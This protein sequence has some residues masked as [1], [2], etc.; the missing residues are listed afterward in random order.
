MSRLGTLLLV[1]LLCIFKAASGQ[2]VPVDTVLKHIREEKNIAR[3]SRLYNYLGVT[4]MN[5]NVPAATGFAR[6]AIEIAQK[7]KFYRELSDAYLTLGYCYE[8]AGRIDDAFLVVDSSKRAADKV[9]YYKGQFF[10]ESSYG[11]LFR[12]K[13][14]YDSSLLHY[15]NAMAIADK[16]GDDTL[17]A[18]GYNGLGNYYATVKDIKKAEEFHLQALEIRK[19]LGNPYDLYSNYENLGILYREQENYDKALFYYFKAREYAEQTKDSSSLA[20]SDND[21]GAAYS[22]KNDVVKGEFFLKRSIAIRERMGEMNELAYTYNYLGENYERKGDL[23]NAEL[24]IKKAL[25]FAKSIKNNKQIY[26]A[27]ES[28]SD[29]YSR[30]KKYDSA[31][32]YLAQYRFFRDSL[33]KKD[34]AKVIAELN[35][36]YETEKK[37]RKIQAQQFEINK[38][39][40]FIIAISGLLILL[41]LL[42]YSLYRRYRLKQQSKLQAE[43]LKQQELAS[44]AVIEA[45][46]NERKRIAGDLH[47]GVGQLMSAVKLNLSSIR[48][49]IPFPS[50]EQSNVFDKAI[51]LVDE[52]CKEVRN[53]SHNIMPNALL[54]SGLAT[55]VRDFV[56]KIDNKAIKIHLYAE[57]LTEK[58]DANAEIVLYRVIQESVNNVIKH[59][60]ANQLHISLIKDDE[61]ISVTIEDNG[62]GFDATDTSRY[63]GIGLKNIRTRIEYLKGTVEW[64]SAPGKGTVVAIHVPV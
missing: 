26:E 40:G 21:I 19:K 51:A 60:G 44:K 25:N 18:K 2:P 27:L 48:N 1:S 46:E 62:K 13:A 15:M 50:E 59:S 55:A 34:N 37:E 24:Y 8:A 47:D 49:D 54:K 7:G 39:N 38:R 33:S 12:R 35:T 41:A 11:T 61:G 17:R 58:I 10:A 14:K 45:E 28:L 5:E 43:I 20:F 32:A 57:G 9:N 6:K 63:E 56:N 52:G 53:V 31:Y 23:A 16:N 29:F 4:Q 30:N 36:R 3:Q 42:G 22:K 64:D